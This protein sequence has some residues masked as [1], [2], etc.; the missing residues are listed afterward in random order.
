MIKDKF[1]DNIK[2]YKLL[3][4]GDHVLIGVSGGVDSIALLYLLDSCKEE[5][6]ITLRVAH[7]NH[8]VRKK[9]AEM[10]LR[11][12]QNLAQD[13]KIPIKIESIDVQKIAKEQKLSLET[14]ARQ[15]RYDFFER[16]AGQEGASKIA[17]G[18]TADDNVETFLMRLVRGS[19]LKGLCGIPPK[20]GKIIRP[21]I[22][23]WRK[24]IESYVGSLKLVP[25]RDYTNY[26]SKYMRNRVRMKL[27][28]QLKLY[29]LNIKEII[30]Q[31]ILLLTQ[32]RLYLEDKA[33]EALA[34]ALISMEENELSL[35]VNKARSLEYAVR[36]HLLRLAIERIKGN[37]LDLCYVHIQDILDN[38]EGK[39]KWEMHLPAGIYVA[40]NSERLLISREKP[41]KHKIGTYYY[42]LSIPG[43]VELKEIGRKLR[44]SLIEDFSPAK[45]NNNDLQTAYVDHAALG[46]NLLARN[47]QEG[48]RFN[49]LGMKGSKKLQDLFVDE[50]IPAELRDSIP[51]IESGGK[52]IWV[53]GVRIDERVKIT[54]NTKKVVKL[55]LL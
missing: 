1:L 50:K 14:A 16:V 38:L 13:L 43:E 6:G 33:E 37:L 8:M 49:P 32:D 46:K 3:V 27:I 29:N 54:K 18:H 45:I 47:K 52:I 21:L 10:D 7:L 39:D 35:D 36:G 2:E 28:P 11:F 4:P 44:T 24:E 42:S 12:V 25:R 34:R 17:V 41:Q 9:D 22:R 40:G 20:R 19:G 48:D 26:E 53:A 23:I 5:L 55:E 30:L 31:T 51:I 15:V